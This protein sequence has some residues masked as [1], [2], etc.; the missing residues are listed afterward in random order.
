MK[1]ILLLVL[2]CGQLTMINSQTPY[3][4]QQVNYSINVSLNDKDHSLDGFE[5]IEYINNSP[6]TLK[7]IWFHLWPNAYKNDK[8]AFSDQLLENGNTKFYFSDKEQKGYINHLDFKVNNSTATTED[9]PQH[10]D[11][12]KLILPTPLAPGQK[13]IIST[14]FHVKL[15]YNFSRGGHDGQS[16]QVT[17]WYPKPAVYDKQGW[18]PMPY[19]DQGEFYSEFGDFD[20]NITVPKNYVVAATGDLQTAA[21]KEW[22]KSRSS[23]DWKPVTIKE[24]IKGGGVKT[25]LQL[26]PQSDKETKT[27]EYKQNNVHDFAWFADKRFIVDQDT[28]QLSTGKV[29]DVYSYYTTLHKENWSKS[30]QFIKDGTRHYSKLV[31]EYPYHQVSVV[32]GPESFGGGMEYPTITVISPVKTTAALDRVIAHE[33]GHNWFYGILASNEREHPWMDEGINSF[34]ESSYSL[35]K[36]AHYNQRNEQALLETFIAEKKDQPIETTSENFSAINYGL[37]AY[38]KT[39]RW[40]NWLEQYLGPSDFQKG[41]QEYYRQWQ[42]K[43]PQPEDL[44]KV[45]ENTSG[46]NLDSAFSLLIKKGNLPGTARTGTAFQLPYGAM[47]SVNYGKQN[48]ITV[49]PALGFNSYDKLMLGLHI[50]NLKLSPN[51]LLFLFSPLYGTGSKSFAGIGFVNY[52]FYPD[53]I[54][55]KIDLG[56]SGARFSIDQFTTPEDKKIFMGV[57]KIVPAIRF[58]FKEKNP[59]STFYQYLQF[60]SFLIGE[61]GLRFSRDSIFTPTDTIIV[62]NYRTAR[63]QRTLHQLALVIENNRALYPYRGELKIEQG[64]DF[65]R[66]GFTG[67]YFFNYPKEGGLQVRFFAGKFFYTSPKTVSKEFATDRYHLN[68]T[69]PNG[70]EDYTYSDYFAGRNKF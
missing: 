24:K 55:R 60:K 3:W 66:S 63:E 47:R 48:I 58:T 51:R 9:H 15:P 44:K 57:Q 28:C 26:F 34:Y 45:L 29:I 65:I 61:D 13:T 35:H 16:Y 27:L 42:F 2:V 21:E 5:R 30:V 25:T 18:H 12:V 23:Y 52:S 39:S 6:D 69:G 37:V 67:N 62:N 20:V 64:E 10:I 54:F 53:G 43:H 17:Q 11:I 40:M 59:R 50:T 70:Y 22:L 4:Q 8:T 41:M 33:I 38:Y 56:I 7:F 14:T 49:L 19:L 46:K 68:M 32:Q 1:K 31:G 36:D